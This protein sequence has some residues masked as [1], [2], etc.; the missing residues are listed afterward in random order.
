MTRASEIPLQRNL[1]DGELADTRTRRQKKQDRQR[2]KPQQPL[3][4]SQAE[5]A[6]FGVKANP[7]FSLSP[8]TGL[9]LLNEDPRTEEQKQLDLQR[10]AEDKTHRLFSPPGS[11][12]E[13]PQASIVVMLAYALAQPIERVTL[14]ITDP[15]GY[16]EQVL[17]GSL[18]RSTVSYTVA[19]TPQGLKLRR[20]VIPHSPPQIFVKVRSKL[21]FVTVPSL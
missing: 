9:A 20:P 15:V 8:T 13:D 21:P 2:Q 4:F 11:Q 1:F 19:T 18:D 16:L 12:T 14:A 5:V 7:L 3:M 6:Q 17:N 10:E